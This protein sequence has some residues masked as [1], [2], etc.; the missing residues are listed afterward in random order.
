MND[1]V[2]TVVFAV[3][4]A[5]Y[6]IFST[7]AALAKVKAMKRRYFVAA[8]LLSAIWAILAAIADIADTAPPVLLDVAEMLRNGSWIG[9]L[10]T[11]WG[12]L[13]DRQSAAPR[14]ILISRAG[15]PIL[16]VLLIVALPYFYNGR[17]AAHS[18]LVLLSLVNIVL[19]VI[20]L[21]LIENVLRT[22]GSS[23]RW[24]IKHLCLGLGT[25][26]TFGFFVHSD[27]LVEGGIDDAFS[28]AH[29]LIAVLV[30]PLLMSSFYRLKNWNFRAEVK[31]NASPKPALYT[32][33]LIASGSYLLIMAA[34]AYYVH[35]IGGRWGFSFQI[36]LMVAAL[37]IMLVSLTSSQIKSHIKV[38]ILKNFFTYRY[39][40]RE[41]WLRFIQ[42]MSAQQ[43]SALE[44]RLARALTDMMNSPAGALWVLQEQDN[45]FFVNAVWNLATPH[46]PVRADSSLIEFFRR[47]CRIIDVDEY[48][49]SPDRY[50][51]LALP[52]WITDRPTVWLVVPLIHRSDIL[53]FLVLDQ[54]RAR[55]RLDWEDRDLLSTAAI[56]AASYLAEE[57][58]TEELRAA[59]RLEDFNRQFA[60]VV[61]DI[62]N[63]VG[64][65]SLMLENAKKYGDNP[66]F[67]KD[68]LET[69]GNSVNRMRAML[70]QLAA[71][72]RQPPKPQ[73]IELTGV[74]GKIGARWNKTAPNLLCELPS[75][76]VVVTAVEAT[77]ISVLDLLID[78]AL[79]ASG[80]TGTV[81]LR[82]RVDGEKIII[83]VSDNGPGMEESFVNTELFR[84]LASTKSTGYG[85]GAYQTRH[86]VREMGAQLE[87]DTAPQQ[88]TTMRIVISPG[89]APSLASPK[90]VTRES[91]EG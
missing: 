10:L 11:L 38:L 67:Q 90:D 45:C 28:V 21:L 91:G 13:D 1:I 89:T 54:A 7:V 83:E 22:S 43:P 87:V 2:G 68:M 14:R 58:T 53:G 60:F 82:L 17:S 79:S 4:A 64:Q 44:F 6:L 84:P 30:A 12:R 5:V 46:P 23:G 32:V 77:L 40:Y 62:K 3:C 39:D 78:N 52:E 15:A 34:L 72:R 63:V 48:R 59:R 70:E 19:P 88:G 80:P 85:I 25:L 20:G 81:V 55:H 61:H 49:Q 73:P 18:L 69:V 37:L 65:M 50:G 26:F 36:T 29:G 42:I 57:L 9:F 56:Q 51:D 33:V 24:E 35:D 75:S 71:Q 76:P 86:L 31:I 16:I 74:L 41:E 47:T 8:C 27:A 66:D